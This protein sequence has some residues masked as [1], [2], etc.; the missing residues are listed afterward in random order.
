MNITL[1]QA[2]KAVQASIEKSKELSL[3]MNIAV[4]DA[5]ANLIAFARMEGAWLGSID[6]FIKKRKLQDY[7]FQKGFETGLVREIVEDLR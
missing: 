1:E 2:Q 6:I 5:G 7:L 4:V 3:K